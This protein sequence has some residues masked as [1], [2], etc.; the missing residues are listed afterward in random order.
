MDWLDK[1]KQYAPDIAAAVVSGGAT[2]PSLAIKAVADAIG[3]DIKDESQL[4]EIVAGSNPDTML[5]LKQANNAFKIRMRE[6]DVELESAEL[7]NIEHARE[8]NKHSRMPS[9][10]CVALTVMVAFGGL[11]LFTRSI[12]PENNEVTYMLFG[13]L[14]TKW[15]DSIAYWVGTTRSSANKTMMLKK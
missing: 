3:T 6:L 15:G 14:L 2:L 5:K 13:A 4:A 8:E 10:I 9:I 7:K 12:P 11:L 1:V